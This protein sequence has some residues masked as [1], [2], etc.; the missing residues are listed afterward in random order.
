MDGP[1]FWASLCTSYLDRL[2]RIQFCSS[3]SKQTCSGNTT[4]NTTNQCPNVFQTIPNPKK[5][6][7]KKKKKTLK[8]K[9]TKSKKSSLLR[10][11]G[12]G[13][14]TTLHPW[15]FPGKAPV[16]DACGLTAGMGLPLGQK[17]PPPG[18]TTG[19]TPSF[20]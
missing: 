9:K 7:Y 18:F 14:D 17:D 16:A 13:G 12:Y 11:D 19:A 6:I 1:F 4:K 3:S 2:R 15:R 20:I 10:K 5:N 8:L